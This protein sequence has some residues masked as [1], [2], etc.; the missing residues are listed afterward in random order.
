TA[1]FKFGVQIPELGSTDIF[2]ENA[3]SLKPQEASRIIK[4][5]SGFY[6]IK[7]KTLSP[8]DEKKYSQEKSSLEQKTLEQKK[9]ERFNQFFEE[10]KNKAR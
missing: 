4:A 7:V 5:A 8:R 10:L 3:N 1:P 9:E 6:I 2:W